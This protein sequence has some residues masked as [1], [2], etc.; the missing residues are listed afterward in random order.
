M[1][2][3][4]QFTRQAAGAPGAARD[5]TAALRSAVRVRLRVQP[6]PLRTARLCPL[7]KPCALWT[8]VALGPWILAPRG[9]GRCPWERHSGLGDGCLAQ[10]SEGPRPASPEASL[11]LGCGPRVPPW[12]PVQLKHLTGSA[13]AG[14]ADETPL[15]KGPL[16]WL[17]VGDPDGGAPDTEQERGWSRSKKDCAPG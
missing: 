7:V 17:R 3:P 6:G 12:C 4:Q 11:C 15:S 9:P 2:G 8:D 1:P 14:S 10:G 5:W 13:G 16:K